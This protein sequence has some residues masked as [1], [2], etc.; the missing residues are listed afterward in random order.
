MRPLLFLVKVY[1]KL[2]KMNIQL[3]SNKTLFMK[4]QPSKENIDLDFR[5]DYEVE[6]PENVDNKFL[7]VIQAILKNK[8]YQLETIFLSEF[9]VDGITDDNFKKSKFPFVYAPAIAYPFFRAF[10]ASTLV[11]N[12]L[13]VHYLP[14]VNFEA[15]FKEKNEK[16]KD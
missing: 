8:D 9:Q 4:D 15:L 2:L 13:E 5:F 11:N 10:V 1:L 12:G 6:F 16:S 7:I 14:S 3:I